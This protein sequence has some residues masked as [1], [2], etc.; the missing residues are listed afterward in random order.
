MGVA[1][2]A[3]ASRAILFTAAVLAAV[4]PFIF[5]YEREVLSEPL[6]LFGVATTIWLGLAK[7]LVTPGP[8][9][10]RLHSASLAGRSR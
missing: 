8:G 3:V 6:A 10:W 4:Y 2:K 7:F 9:H 5:L 1:A